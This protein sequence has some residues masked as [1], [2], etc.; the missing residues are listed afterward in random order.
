MPRTVQMTAIEAEVL[1]LK[2]GFLLVR[3]RG[4]HRIYRRGSDRMV[5]PFHAGRM[6]HPKIVRQIQQA[7][8]SPSGV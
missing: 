1:L 5:V 3:S 4:S 8:E 6:L 2:A 7:V